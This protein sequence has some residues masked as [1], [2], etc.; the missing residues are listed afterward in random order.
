MSSPIAHGSLMFAA[1]PA[2]RSR[3]DPC[4]SRTRR[5]LIGCAMLVGLMA[6]DADLVLGLW[7]PTRALSDYHNGPTHSLFVALAFALTF[8]LVCRAV[9]RLP[10]R[11]LCI[12]GAALYGSHVILDWLTWGRG[13]Q[14]FWP[15]TETRFKAP[16]SLLMGVRHSVGAPVTTHM[17]TVANDLVFGLA[18]WWVSRWVWSRRARSND[19]LQP[20]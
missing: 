17:L 16:V 18:V 14:M 4:L 7:Y 5:A 3:M 19:H 11:F 20:P 15:I 1:W 6:P 2:V 9:V 12:L 13:V 10:W 8:A